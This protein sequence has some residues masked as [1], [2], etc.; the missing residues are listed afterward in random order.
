MPLFRV[1]AFGRGYVDLEICFALF[2]V[3]AWLALWLDRPEREQRSIA[4]LL[5]ALGALAAAAAVL[6]IPGASGHPAQTSPRGLSLAADWLHLISGS[7]WLGGL[8]G[9]L[10]LWRALP[11]GLRVPGLAVCVPRFSN[12]AFCSVGVLLTT[13]IVATVLHMPILA[14]LW[15][16]SY[17]QVILVKSG[18]LAA[19]MGLGAV[20]MLRSTPRLVAARDRPEA[21]QAG[22]DAAPARD[23]R[24]GGCCWSCAVFA[25]AVLSSLAPPANALGRGEQ[26]A[27]PRRAGEGRRDR[28]PRGLYPA[29]PGQ[30]QQGGCTELVRAEADPERQARA[31]TRT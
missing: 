27:R 9:L 28:A 16:T 20:N 22:G 24:R 21:G 2:C 13:G 18:L 15:Q 7:L 6:A 12:V 30:P 26:G 1:T 8:V 10:V 19:A 17:G 4:E 3:A 31:A 25:A 11:A 23:Q 5:S 14:A 29:G